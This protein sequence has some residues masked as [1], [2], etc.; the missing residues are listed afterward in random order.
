V[1][2]S[3]F[4]KHEDAFNLL[5]LLKKIDMILKDAGR[6]DWMFLQSSSGSRDTGTD[7]E[8]RIFTAFLNVGQWFSNFAAR[9]TLRILISLYGTLELE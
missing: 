4:G 2:C 5:Y 8:N 1:L 7:G 3:I 6:T 9:G